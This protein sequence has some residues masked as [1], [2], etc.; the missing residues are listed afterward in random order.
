MKRPLKLLLLLGLIALVTT[1]CYHRPYY[2]DRH[3]H[4]FGGHDHGYPPA[5]V[6]LRGQID[7]HDRDR[8][9][10]RQPVQRPRAAHQPEPDRY[11]ARRDRREHRDPANRRVE[12]SA[13]HDDRG[14][15]TERR[16]AR[17]ERRVRREESGWAQRDGQPE[18]R[19]RRGRRDEWRMER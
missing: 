15:V 11:D 18:Q 16:A 14:D 13:R 8:H 9:F 1:G 5:R 10:D 12:P 7:H 6:I 17:Q 2:A 4:G 3:S 19:E